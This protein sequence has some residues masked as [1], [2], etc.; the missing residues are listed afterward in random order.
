M[1]HLP[2]LALPRAGV[3][4]EQGRPV[5]DDGQAASALARLRVHGLHLRHHVHQEQQRTVVDARQARTEAPRE[6]LL[7]VLLFDFLL[8]LLPLHAERRIRQACS[9]TWPRGARPP[10][11]SCPARC[12]RGSAPSSSCRSCRWRRTRRSAPG[13]RPSGR[14][15]GSAH[16]GTPRRPRA[17][18]P[19]LPQGRRA[20]ERCP[21]S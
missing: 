12:S 10:R 1:T 16:G 7:L 9:R 17:S 20:S 15:R 4:R 5:E 6:A 13:R 21:S 8:D 18:R 11:R 2:N 19:S 3:P 14:P